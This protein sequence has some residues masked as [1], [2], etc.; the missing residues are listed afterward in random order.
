M[1]R[2]ISFLFSSFLLVGIALNAAHSAPCPK[3]VFTPGSSVRFAGKEA[4]IVTHPSTLWDGRYSSKAGMD[5]AVQFAKKRALP[6]IYLQGDYASNTY[7]FADCEPTYW[8]DS[9]GGEFSFDVTAE[10]IYSVGGHWELCQETTLRD[11]MRSWQKNLP[12]KNLTLTQVMDGI[13]TYGEHFK[14]NDSYYTDFSRFM[15][16][17]FYGN[18]RDN[19]FVRK[20]SLLESMGIVKDS[21]QQIEFLKR[22][23]PDFRSFKNYTVELWVNAVKVETLQAGK[24]ASSP[25]MKL[26]FLNSV[27][28]GGDIPA[29]L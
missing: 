6:V 2:T 28:A 8:V 4:L 1:Q 19:W 29:P 18:P 7:F 26:E 25:L 9:A 23:L 13:Y 14:S 27:Y 3:P 21:A 16:I 10:H 20:L 22:N 5:A 12:G 17:I 11:L 24:D 15:E